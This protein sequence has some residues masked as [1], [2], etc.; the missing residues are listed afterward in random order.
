MGGWKREVRIGRDSMVLHSFELPSRREIGAA[1]TVGWVGCVVLVSTDQCGGTVV[2][3]LAHRNAQTAKPPR[4]SNYSATC[5]QVT[6][7]LVLC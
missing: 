3:A 5:A 4:Y 1:L 7:W 2:E 6:F